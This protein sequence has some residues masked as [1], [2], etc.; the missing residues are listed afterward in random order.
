MDK[1]LD[2]ISLAFSDHDEMELRRK[3]VSTSSSSDGILSDGS[4]SGPDE[5]IL[6]SINNT[7]LK[8]CGI[9]NAKHR[10]FIMFHIEKLKNMRKNI[11]ENKD[12]NSDDDDDDENES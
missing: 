9:R 5:P 1:L 3:N 11:H 10:Q 12:E 2:N 7:V 8:M 6:E 4:Y